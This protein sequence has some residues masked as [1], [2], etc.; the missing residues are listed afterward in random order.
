VQPDSG[1]TIQPVALNRGADEENI[2]Q[3][4]W[5]HCISI[6]DRVAAI[7]GEQ[8]VRD[9]ISLFHLISMEFPYMFERMML[10]RNELT[11]N[12]R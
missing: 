5:G 3:V 1:N 2:V 9:E 4:S 8:V 11:M 6:S 12:F 7:F 10:R